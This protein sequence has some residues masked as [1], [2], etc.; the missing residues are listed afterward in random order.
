MDSKRTMNNDATSRRVA[1][2]TAVVVGAGGNIGSHLVPHLGR[3]AELHRVI[4]IDPDVYEAKNVRSQDITPSAVGK[5]KVCIQAR[6][7]RRINPRLHVE[8]VQKEIQDVP[9]G[10][11]EADVILACLDSREARRDVNQKAFRLGSPWIDAGVEPGGLLARVNV[12]KPAP[13]APCLECA[14]HDEDYALLEQRY[15]CGGKASSPAPTNAPSSIGAL[16]ASLQAIECQKLLTGQFERLAVGQ[17]ILIDASH[18]KHYVT[19]LVRN[20]HCR[21][22]HETWCIL[23]H[24]VPSPDITVGEALGLLGN[25][26]PEEGSPAL[27]VEGQAFV[28]AVAC[29]LCGWRR[30]VLRLQ[31]RLRELRCAKCGG[32]MVP[33]GFE[34]V[35]RL[36][37]MSERI[38]HRTLRSLGLRAGDVFSIGTP[39]GRVRHYEIDCDT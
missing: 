13:D 25:P 6:T 5:R 8:T 22:D 28:V 12:Y 3:M 39:L 17:Q 15:A 14:W 4:L 32:R 34:M 24:E 7:L 10:R 11:L 30:R 36:A 20:G 19:K 37:T 2:K 16:A 18:H 33:I 35:E 31:R 1:E 38:Q 26:V 27:W 23:R 9:L 21:F 29:A